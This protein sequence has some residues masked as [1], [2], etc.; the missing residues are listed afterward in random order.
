MKFI[1]LGWNSE[2]RVWYYWPE[3]VSNSFRHK[4][5]S[6]GLKQQDGE[7]NE[8]RILTGFLSPSMTRIFKNSELSSV[9]RVLPFNSWNHLCVFPLLYNGSHLSLPRISYFAY[10]FGGKLKRAFNLGLIKFHFAT[11][12]RRSE[13]SYSWPG[14]ISPRSLALIEERGWE[15]RRMPWKVGEHW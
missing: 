2:R 4:D 10:S 6:F 14:P 5:Q 3:T 12:R 15:R 13:N 8:K 7:G 11:S 9:M 1:I